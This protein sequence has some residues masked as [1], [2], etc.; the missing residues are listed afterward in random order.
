M[1]CSSGRRLIPPRIRKPNSIAG[2]SGFAALSAHRIL[3]CR[4]GYPLTYSPVPTCTRTTSADNC[5]PS[6]DRV[7]CARR[8]RHCFSFMRGRPLLNHREENQAMAYT[9]PDLPYA[10]DALEPTID[11]KTMEIHHDRHHKAYV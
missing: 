5:G 7:C 8:W 2:S 1:Q 4:A 3:S 9:L 11:A 6:I 10:F